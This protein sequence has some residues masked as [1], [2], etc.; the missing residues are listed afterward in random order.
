MPDEA[1]QKNA[2]ALSLLQ[3]L[4]KYDNPQAYSDPN[5]PHVYR[6]R[7]PPKQYETEPV[8]LKIEL[9]GSHLKQS[10]RDLLFFALKD[11]PS[12]DQMME[13]IGAKDFADF[14]VQLTATESYQQTENEVYLFWLRHFPELITKFF[15]IISQV[16]L[17]S[18]PATSTRKVAGS[19]RSNKRAC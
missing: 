17:A 3:D 19:L 7:I 6:L 8:I 11:V 1:S 5:E 10:L 18:L 2:E 15:L 4:E 12:I 14:K 13:Q 9:N 16:A